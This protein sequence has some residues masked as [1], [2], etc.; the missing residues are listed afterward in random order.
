MAKVLKHRPEN[1]DFL[2]VAGTGL[3]AGVIGQARVRAD[4]SNPAGEAFAMGRP[5]AV[6]NL[7]GR[8]DYHL[9]EIF[10]EHGVVSS[11]NVPIIGLGGSYGVLEVD[12]REPRAFDALDLSFLAS[13]AEIVADAV[14]R[15]RRHSDLQAVYEAKDLLLREH[16]HRAR[17]SY[18][19][20]LARLQRHKGQAT[21]EDSRRRFEDV[22]RR[23]FALAS[24]YDHLVGAVGGGELDVC[25]Y[26]GDLC[27]RMRD[28]YATEERGID[29]A[30]DCPD[31]E[32]RFDIDTCT[33]LGTVVNELVA[34]AVEH[35]FAAGGGRIRVRLARED[36]G[37]ALIVED[38][39]PGFSEP[40]SQSIGLDVAHRL[41][42]AVGGKLTRMH[43]GSGAAW[44][45]ALPHSAPTGRKPEAA[46]VAVVD[47]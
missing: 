44:S 19:I 23:V 38:D 4:P 10:A 11:A 28:F 8:L 14:E 1:G 33:A 21:T 31:I 29:L 12:A 17:N 43:T 13:V 39:G 40:P 46:E 34:N 3:L 5:V 27:R 16:H 20:I 7:R 37:P 47:G 32:L 2:I 26:V 35:A 18:Q 6:P 42:A 9:P 15:V 25:R 30:A 45:I 22:E 36:G 24:L 41:I